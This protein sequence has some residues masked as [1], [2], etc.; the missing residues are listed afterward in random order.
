[1]NPKFLINSGG[2]GMLQGG[3]ISNRM[4]SQQ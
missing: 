2:E 3:S 4:E 1:L